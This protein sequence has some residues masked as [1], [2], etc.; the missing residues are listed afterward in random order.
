MKKGNRIVSNH[1]IIKSVA[2]RTGFTMTKV[3]KMLAALNEVVLKSL[4]DNA[5]IV[6]KGFFS[7]STIIRPHRRAFLPQSGIGTLPER[8]RVRMK[9]LMKLEEH[10]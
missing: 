9:S 6:L 4:S 2:E 10:E 3:R 1:T 5:I 7:A 8:R